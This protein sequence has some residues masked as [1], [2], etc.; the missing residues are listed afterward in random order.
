MKVLISPGYGAGWS[1]WNSGEV[2]AYMRA[3][4]PIIDALES[5]EEMSEEHPLVV[6]MQSEIKDKFG[7]EYVCVLGAEQLCV[8][9]AYPPFQVHEYDGSESITTPGESD[10]WVME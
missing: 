10:D 5:G 8:V 4:Q 9:H 2:A 7:E 3:Y 6:Q 1:S